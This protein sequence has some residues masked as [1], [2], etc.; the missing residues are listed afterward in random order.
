MPWYLS[1]TI[2]GCLTRFLN[3]SCAFLLLEFPQ[4]LWDHVKTHRITE[5]QNHRTVW[6]GRHLRDAPSSNPVL[7]TGLPPTRS[8]PRAPSNLASNT[9][10]DGASTAL[11]ATCA[12]TSPPLSKEFPLNISP[13]CCRSSR[14]Q[15]KARCCSPVTQHSAAMVGAIPAG[16][17]CS[18]LAV[19]PD[20][21]DTKSFGSKNF[22]EKAK[23]ALGL[24]LIICF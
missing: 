23:V 2:K 1:T 13:A 22:V 3:N 24:D 17:G 11:W 10:R 21:W 9:S 6:V 7:W 12:S 20:R 19:L 5:S 4:V 18:C 8:G 15:G 14:K 16:G